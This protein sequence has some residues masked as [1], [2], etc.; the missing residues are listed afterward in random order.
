MDLRQVS[1]GEAT[2]LFLTVVGGAGIRSRWSFAR[3]AEAVHGEAARLRRQGIRRGD[4]VGVTAGP[5]DQF[6]VAWYALWTL[7]A[8]VVPLNPSAPADDWQRTLTIAQA[9]W[10]WVLPG[11]PVRLAAAPAREGDSGA[12]MILLTS[13]STGHPKPVGLAAEQ[14]WLVAREVQKAHQL[15]PSDHEFC[16][17]PLFHVNALVVGVLTSWATGSRLTLPE[18]G[19]HRRVFWHQVQAVKPSWL[20]LAPSILHILMDEPPLKPLP[21]LR[22]VRSASA[23]LPAMIRERVEREWGIPVIETYGMTEAGSQIAANPWPPDRRRPGTVG[24]GFGVAMRVVDQDGLPVSPGQSGEVEISGPTVI[25]PQWGPNRWARLRQGWYRTGDIG[26]LDA[27]GYLTL[28]GRVRDLINR[29]GEKIS[30]R[31]VE[32]WLLQAS[33]VQDVAVVGRP[34]PV[35]GEEPVAFV[36][37]RETR[38]SDRLPE[39]LRVWAENGL[40]RFKRPADYFIVTRLPKGHT[41]KVQRQ[42]LRHWLLAGGGGH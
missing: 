28:E 7:E 22:M 3:L 33:G 4:R 11:T 29:G 32:E 18:D 34:H 31:E 26:R 16:P 12:G 25:R 38:E 35:L 21:P 24:I 15:S 36:V 23:P 30:P 10:L 27:D 6:I 39:R 42:E 8:V 41:G 1:A 13:G 19:F 14:L 2:D 5:P 20:N 37:P 17:L 9:Q 40:D